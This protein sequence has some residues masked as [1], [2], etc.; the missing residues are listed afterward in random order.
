[1]IDLKKFLDISINKKLA[2]LFLAVTLGFLAIATTYWL[3]L[4]NERKSTERSN[5]FIEYGQL[6][7][8]AQKN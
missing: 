4:K 5:L 6:V 1:M 7:S 8:D 3:V 2:I